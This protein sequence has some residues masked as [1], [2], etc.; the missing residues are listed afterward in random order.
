MLE[1]LEHLNST[2]GLQVAKSEAKGEAETTKNQDDD[3]TGN[4]N[5]TQAR[6]SHSQSAILNRLRTIDRLVEELPNV[7]RDEGTQLDIL[8]QLEDKV[9]IQERELQALTTERAAL[10]QHLYKGI[11]RTTQLINETR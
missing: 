4:L 1:V 5:T 9:Q 6:S 2:P 8:R 10:Q 3:T 11:S 7:G